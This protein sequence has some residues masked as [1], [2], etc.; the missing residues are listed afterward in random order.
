MPARAEE[1]RHGDLRPR[2]HGHAVVLVVHLDV[3]QRHVVRGADVEAV[4]VVRRGLGAGRRVGRVAGRVVEEDVLGRQVL[5][6]RDVEAVRGPVLD[7]EARDGRV[8]GLLDHEEVVRLLAASVAALTVPVRLPVAVDYVAWGA[9]QGDVVAGHDD[10]VEVLICC[11]PERRGSAEGD[12]STWLQLLEVQS[13]RGRHGDVVQEYVG[14]R[15]DCRRNIGGSSDCACCPAV[16]GHG[17]TR[18]G[19]GSGRGSSSTRRGSGWPAGDGGRAAA[20]SK[21]GW[22]SSS[23]QNEG[24]HGC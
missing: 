24:L 12:D 4:R 2:R 19:R 5:V 8:G 9:G 23:C 3:A 7:V 15:G 10:G 6:A 16:A 11:G 13:R 17:S 14:A 1:P 22:D 21:H 20:G 18:R